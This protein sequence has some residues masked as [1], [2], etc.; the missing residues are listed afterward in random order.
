MM[1]ATN[2]LQLPQGT[3]MM[4]L[5]SSDHLSLSLSTPQHTS[6]R[7]AQREAR[8]TDPQANRHPA[9]KEK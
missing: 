2:H 6:F 7:V 8:N 3:V 5:A 9:A 4:H 1:L